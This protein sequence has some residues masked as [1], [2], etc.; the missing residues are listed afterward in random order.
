VDGGS[1]IVRSSRLLAPIQ[2]DGQGM[3]MNMR[4]EIHTQ[5]WGKTRRKE[6]TGTPMHRWED[7]IKIELKWKEGE[8]WINLA[9]N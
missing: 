3:W 2:G 7:T 6:T 1:C 5:F 8:D 9:Q 4:N